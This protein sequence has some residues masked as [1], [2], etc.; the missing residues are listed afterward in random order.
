M[1]QEA[2]AHPPP[3]CRGLDPS[4]RTT[5]RKHQGLSPA[6]HRAPLQTQ[7]QVGA[8]FGALRF[9]SRSRGQ[10]R[11]LL[12]AMRMCPLLETHSRAAE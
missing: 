1:S 3:I 10:P 7:T 12:T 5:R 6:A 8:D 9:G 2:G 4:L 11:T